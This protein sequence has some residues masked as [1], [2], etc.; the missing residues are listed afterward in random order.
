[1]SILRVLLVLLFFAVGAAGASYY[2]AGR[3]EGPTI[4]VHQPQ[5]LVGQAGTL[6]LSVEAPGGRL[7]AITVDL[8]QGGRRLPVF[9]LGSGSDAAITQETADR[10]RIRRPLGK[11]SVPELQPG[12]AR[13][14]AMASR[15]VLFGLRTAE[16]RVTRDVTARFEPPRVVVVST[17]HYVNHGGSEMTMYRVTPPDVE[18]GVRVGEIRYPGFRVAGAGT[19]Q[20]P[21]VKIAF[22]ALLY[23]QDLG[24]PI[25]LYAIDE[26][27]NEARASI[28]TRAFPKPFLRSRIDLEE[29]FLARV[30]PAILRTSPELKTSVSSPDDLLPAFLKINGD[31]R[32]MN[33]EKIKELAA[34]TAPEMLWKGAFQQLGNSQ[35]ESRFADH[36]TYFYRGK[37]VD[38]QVHLGFDLAVTR[39][40]PVLASNRGKVIYA[41]DLGIYGNCVVVDHGLGVQSL[42]GH[43]SSFDVKVGDMVG[44]GQPLGRSGMTGLAGGDHLHFSMLV[45]GNPVSAVDWWDPHWVEDRIVRKLKESGQPVPAARTAEPR[46]AERARP[47]TTRPRSRRGS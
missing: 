15:P 44:K 23:D 43:L 25:E 26:A 20:D 11:R 37:E 6:D 24:T 31:L 41:G 17:H 22:F 40:V 42:Y 2:L 3:A 1:M 4:E 29:P 39:A 34:N 35:V 5:K 18:S 47:L 30:V 38:R 21:S 19:A 12:A 14:V 16:S 45:N 13:I 9:T 7:T 8:E 10:I 46:P 33:A 36:R 32:R 27:G 28:D